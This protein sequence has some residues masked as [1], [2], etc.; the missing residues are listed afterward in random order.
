M[1][2]DRIAASRKRPVRDEPPLCPVD[3]VRPYLESHALLRGLGVRVE[4]VHTA[5]IELRRRRRATDPRPVAPIVPPTCTACNQG[6]LVRDTHEG[7]EVCDLCGVVGSRTWIGSTFACPPQIVSKKAKA[8]TSRMAP[9]YQSSAGEAPCTYL[10]EALNWNVLVGLSEADATDVAH[11]LEGW[12]DGRYR[13]DAKL[14]AGLL[15]PVLNDRLPSED[16]VRQSLQFGATMEVVQD[17]TPVPRFAC[18]GC[19]ALLH[20][21]KTARYHCRLANNR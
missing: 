18:D 21:K 14:A 8:T 11:E 20:T 9:L 7:Y 16:A 6:Y 19:G 1:L 10:E 13:R 17:P 3:A 2:R 15:L 4:E 5:L 12:K